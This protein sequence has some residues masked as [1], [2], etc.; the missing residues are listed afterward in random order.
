MK[1][2][3]SPREYWE[4]IDSIISEL[5]TNGFV[6]LPSLEQ[7]PLEVLA[8]NIIHE[9]G[10]SNFKEL[11]KW[12][13]RFLQILEVDEY[14]SPKLFELAINAFSYKGNS[15]NQYHIARYV[16]RGNSKEQYRAHFDS[17]LFTIVFPIKIPSA[18]INGSAGEL[19]YFPNIRKSPK[20]EL[21][22]F[23]GKL[24][25]KIFANERGINS[26][27]ARS[28]LFI[29]DFKDQRPLLFLGN[30]TLHTNR[31]V[32]LEASSDRLTLLAHYFDPSPSFGIG[33]IL[34]FLRSR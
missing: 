22:N 25:Y 8:D 2:E 17:H 13:K 31:S 23:M 27:A 33:N 12:H 14:L 29:D 32:S 18:S 30:T 5:K 16:D 28:P 1:S 6:K 26:L 24:Y 20:N 34:R 21:I 3:F 10:G 9:M 15:N 7:L 4:N 11:G 19:L